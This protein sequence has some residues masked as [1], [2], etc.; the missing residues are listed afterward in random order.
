M[1]THTHHC[2]RRITRGANETEEERSVSSAAVREE[3]HRSSS[4]GGNRE[5]A[6]VV[7]VCTISW[8][9][10]EE[11]ANAPLLAPPQQ[12]CHQ[13]CGILNDNDKA[14]CIPCEQACGTMITDG[15]CVLCITRDSDSNANLSLR[16]LKYICTCRAAGNKMEYPSSAVM[17]N[18]ALLI[19][20]LQLTGV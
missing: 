15:R 1:R 18:E 19:L 20:I 6:F 4:A 13:V 10:E 12:L 2:R 7:I 9:Y 17:Y 8:N 5:E 16:P 3:Q 11:N 14:G